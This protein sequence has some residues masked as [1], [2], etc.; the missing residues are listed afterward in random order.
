MCIAKMSMTPRHCTMPLCTI[1]KDS[2]IF[3][4]D[5]NIQTLSII[6]VSHGADPNVPDAYGM[7]PTL[8]ACES[9]HCDTLTMLLKYV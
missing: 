6:L 4:V 5:A 8:L 9:G 2:S 7:T 3:F 1:K